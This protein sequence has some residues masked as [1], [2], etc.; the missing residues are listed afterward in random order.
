MLIQFHGQE[1]E[2]AGFL[3]DSN[4]AIWIKKDDNAAEIFKELYRNQE[5]LETMRENA[6]NLAKPN[7]TKNICKI[8]LDKNQKADD[9][10]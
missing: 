5:N 2:N 3:V 9:I 7:S 6:K 4:C 1:E 8:L 10:F